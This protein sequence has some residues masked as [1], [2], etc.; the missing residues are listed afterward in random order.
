M[1]ARGGYVTLRASTYMFDFW[2]GSLIANGVSVVAPTGETVATSEL[3]TVR[4]P[5]HLGGPA[6]ALSV[7]AKNV[8]ATLI[9]DEQ[10]RF[11]FLDLLPPEREEP[12]E[13]PFKVDLENAVV[14]VVDRSDP[15][16]FTEVLTLPHTAIDG[17]GDVWRASGSFRQGRGGSASLS[18]HNSPTG[19]WAIEGTL[20]ALEL[21]HWLGPLRRSRGAEDWTLL[22]KISAERLWARGPIAIRLPPEGEAELDGSLIAEGRNVRYGEIFAQS[23]LLR[24]QFNTGELYGWLDL[25]NAKAEASFV[26]RIAWQPE[27][28]AEGNLVM[29]LHD[30]TQV[31]I[32]FRSE[33]PKEL[34]FR[35]LRYA[36]FM[37]YESDR[38]LS[39]HGDARAALAQWGK[40]SVSSPSFGVRLEP[41]FASIR[42]FTGVY[43]D[44]PIGGS[45]DFNI[46]ARTMSAFASTGACRIEEFRERTGLD[47]VYGL[48]SLQAIARGSFDSPDVEL[49]AQGT[50]SAIVEEGRVT[51]LGPFHAQARY[52]GPLVRIERLAITGK[53]GVASL[54]GTFNVETRQL[55]LEGVASGIDLAALHSRLNGTAAGSFR[56]TGTPEAYLAQGPIEVY[57]LEIEDQPIPL[58]AAQIELSPQRLLAREVR[59]TRGAARLRGEAAW[60][61]ENDALSGQFSAESVQLHDFLEEGFEGSVDMLQGEVAGTL[62]EPVLTGQLRGQDLVLRGVR[63]DTASG[64]VRLEGADLALTEGLVTAESGR[65]ELTAS[66]DLESRTGRAQGTAEGLPIERVQ[67]LLPPETGLEGSFDGNFDAAIQDGRLATFESD[68]SVEGLHVNRSFLGNGFFTLNGE[69][70][71]WTGT[72]ELGQPERFIQVPEFTYLAETDELEADLVAYGMPLRDLYFAA[73]PYFV[74]EPG[75]AEARLELPPNIRDL[76][77]R[78]QGSL[79]LNAHISGS[80]TDP[81]LQIDSLLLRETTVDGEQT[82]QVQLVATRNERLWAIQ[83]LEWTG[84]PGVLSVTG[85]AQEGGQLNLDG[86]VNNF[87][88]VW[89]ARFIPA[90]GSV[91]GEA[92]I[93][94]TATG[95][96]SSPL[97]EASF[98]GALFEGGATRVTAEGEVVVDEDKKLHVDI[99]PILVRDGQ[100]SMDGSFRYRGFTGVLEGSIPFRYPG[101]F[102]KDEAMRITLKSNRP[103]DELK[104]LFANI[105]PEKT[106]GR[107]SA[108]ILVAGPVGSA[109]V[110]GTIQMEAASFGL[111]NLDTVFKDV[112]AA[113]NLSPES[114]QFSLTG[115]PS[116]GGRI[117]LDANLGLDDM[118]TAFT[119]AMRGSF[120]ILLAHPINGKLT[121]EDIR[122]QETH[123]ESGSIEF[124]GN[125][126]VLLDGPLGRPRIHTESPLVLENVRGTVPTLVIEAAATG[127]PIVNPVFDVDY[128]VASRE[129]PAEVRAATSVLD[130]FGAG[131]LQG[132]LTAL[133]A[134]ADFRVEGGS[135]RLPNARIAIQEGGSVRMR[136][137]GGLL[138]PE[139]RLDVDLE[140]RTSLTTIRFS[141]LLERYD[142]YLQIRGNLLNP[143]EQVIT[144]RSDPPDLTQERI[145]SLL[146]QIELVETISGQFLGT[147]RRNELQQALASLAVPALFDPITEELA[148]QFGLEYLSLSY[149]PF[150]QTTVTAAKW[151]GKGFTLQGW[152]EISE[153]LDGQQDF[154]LRLTYR[155]PRRIRQLRN[156]TFSLGIDQERP[157][158]L[159]VEYSARLRNSGA[160]NRS[161][162]IW[163]GA[164]PKEKPS[165]PIGPPPPSP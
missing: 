56:V 64:L 29:S 131:T 155:P 78:V 157:W 101:E 53:A 130:I 145:L 113:A 144:A 100:I 50:A 123:G 44:V 20:A 80:V 6:P 149:G 146:G 136:Y 40:E 140:G 26:G 94:F 23:G 110:S 76:L 117:A 39:L 68:G 31:P 129:N 5:K 121:L 35:E 125:G 133:D 57:G 151:L 4:L 153:P 32:E 7:R 103:L 79:D 58:V 45:G 88:T 111:T 84:G 9:R 156:L 51:D 154:D 66:Y 24:A 102:P 77:D 16:V 92:D 62:S 118:A 81:N 30:R 65:L 108:D 86:N 124:V 61:F 105:D 71:R 85:T 42:E 122:I 150:G 70:D 114:V 112:K 127:E 135:I 18:I 12:S 139:L 63:L 161:N 91:T 134:T 48:A 165:A 34:S 69:G 74:P 159:S 128:T 116:R 15:K 143:E 43:N 55:A 8:D 37:R 97:I 75:R 47:R 163:I 119:E 96:T 36:G 25:A 132:P 11:M 98:S 73:R 21:A 87:S 162:V 152:K 99:Y 1:E 115:N 59:A 142:I 33:L 137:D 126:S 106:D 28:Q 49:R 41:E 54:A 158:K 147:T 2:S 3:M 14:T 17:I 46:K 141:T 38:G 95:E 27:V 138:E 107:V 22:E 109:V 13:L 52:D 104:D 90:F 160:R 10:G 60:I 67:P 164:E 93:S 83:K 19:G 72:L 120:D 89:L 148:R 82:G